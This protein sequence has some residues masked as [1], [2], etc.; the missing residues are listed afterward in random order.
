MTKRT[1]DAIDLAIAA[2][3]DV[4]APKRGAGLVLSVPG[5]QPT[6]IIDASGRLTPPWQVL[7]REARDRAASGRNRQDFGPDP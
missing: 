1:R 5:G 4:R 6:R 3:E 2:G 7:L